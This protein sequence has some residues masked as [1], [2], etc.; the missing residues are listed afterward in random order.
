MGNLD[1]SQ[2]QNGISSQFSSQNS[3]QIFFLL[4]WV[5]EEVVVRGAV[6]SQHVLLGAGDAAE[7]HHL[8]GFDGSLRK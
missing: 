8:R 2:N 6:E 5:P 7:A 1:M 3:I 4:N